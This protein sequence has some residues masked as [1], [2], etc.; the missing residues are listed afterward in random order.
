MELQHGPNNFLK[1]MS[2]FLFQVCC[3]LTKVTLHRTKIR[4][5]LFSTSFK[6]K[7]YSVFDILQIHSKNVDSFNCFVGYS[8]Y[9]A[10]YLS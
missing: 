10:V 7:L 3:V 6:R 8:L 1:L 5:C 2:L 9:S 4:K